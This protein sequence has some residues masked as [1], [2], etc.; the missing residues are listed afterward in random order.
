[1]KSCR[2]CNIEKPLDSFNKSKRNKDGFNNM[3]KECGKEYAK[4]YRKENYEM[5]IQKEREREKSEINKSIRKKYR[6]ENKLSR[7]EY[8]KKY[9]LENKDK[10]LLSISNSRKKRYHNDPN[11]KLKEL[12]RGAIKNSIKRKGYS[13][14]S[15]TKNILGCS[16]DE[17][18]H[19]IESLWENWMNWDNFG[20]PKD[21]VL[22]ENKSWDIDH[23]IPISSAETE[24]DVIKLNHYTNLQPLCSYN[25]R[26]IKKDK[27]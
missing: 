8:Y 21:G 10:V 7:S 24:E 1:M 25:N 5:I 18:R 19:H 12:I 6:E 13:K 9:R 11:Y 4:K 3:C 15:N 16:Y 27:F 14:K 17:F 20:N 23:I 2:V 22:G 26:L